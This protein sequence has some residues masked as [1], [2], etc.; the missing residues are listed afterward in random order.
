V[1]AVDDQ[2]L[3]LEQNVKEKIAIGFVLFRKLF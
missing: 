3:A 2:T 1:L